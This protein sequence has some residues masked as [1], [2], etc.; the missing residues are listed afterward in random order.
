VLLLALIFAA[1]TST[2]VT[3][4]DGAVA[5]AQSECAVLDL[6]ATITL[7]DKDVMRI[8]NKGASKCEPFRLHL[9]RTH[10]DAV[11][12][13]SELTTTTS[14]FAQSYSATPEPQPHGKP[15][16]MPHNDPLHPERCAKFKNT[17][18]RFDQGRVVMGVF[19]AK[20]GSLFVQF[21]APK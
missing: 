16:A 8:Y 11:V 6:C 7:P 20:N 19:L 21:S 17:Y 5:E 2:S 15:T 4:S 13:D 3:Y 1:Y 14:E 9:V 12:L 18:F 10:G